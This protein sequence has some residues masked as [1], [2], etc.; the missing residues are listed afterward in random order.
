MDPINT[1]GK[2]LIETHY[3]TENVYENAN[4]IQFHFYLEEEELKR[5][6]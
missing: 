5:P 1:V 3:K 6:V 2:V 4:R